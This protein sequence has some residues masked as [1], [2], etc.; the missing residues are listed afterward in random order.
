[1]DIQFK[2]LLSFGII[3]C[4]ELSLS[5]P[6]SSNFYL[7]IYLFIY[8]FTMSQYLTDIQNKV[9]GKNSMSETQNKIKIKFG[10]VLKLNVT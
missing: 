3:L 9:Q 2:M 4:I 8:L 1:M 7:F 10:Q 6:I 5:T